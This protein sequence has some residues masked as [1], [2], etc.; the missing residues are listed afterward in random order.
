VLAASVFH[1]GVYSIA[2]VK[3]ALVKEGFPVRK[4]W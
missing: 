3:K 1:F 2:Q 4:T